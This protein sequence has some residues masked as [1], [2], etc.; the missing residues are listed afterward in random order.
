MSTLLLCSAPVSN[1]VFSY[2]QDKWL[3]RHL[4]F[5]AAIDSSSKRAI[6]VD[7]ASHRIKRRKLELVEGSI[8]VYKSEAD[9]ARV[10][11]SPLSMFSPPGLEVLFQ[12]PSV[13]VLPGHSNFD[14][15]IGTPNIIATDKTRFIEELDKAVEYQYMFFRPRRWGKTTFLQMLANYY[16]KTKKDQ[17]DDTFGQ[18]YIGK[19]PTQD[20]SS[21]LVLLFDFSTVTTSDLR[22]TRKEFNGMVSV[23]L[24]NFLTWNAE[25]LGDVDAKQLVGE[26]GAEAIDRV[27]VSS[28]LLMW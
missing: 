13:V 11:P 21:L 8:T 3:I 23:A 24:S 5:K 17:F 16:D 15:L 12:Q 1:C 20:R 2:R 25:I 18:L 14:H 9:L 10:S 22:E 7:R 27:L 28:R 6:H 26:G 19:N 4:D